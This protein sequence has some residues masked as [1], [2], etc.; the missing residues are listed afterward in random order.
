MIVV[1]CILYIFILTP[2]R[3][4]LYFELKSSSN[5]KMTCIPYFLNPND[6]LEVCP[7]ATTVPKDLFI[8]K[9]VLYDIAVTIKRSVIGLMKNVLVF[10]FV[11]SGISICRYLSIM[12]C[13][14]GTTSKDLQIEHSQKQSQTSSAPKVRQD[15]FSTIKRSIPGVKP[16]R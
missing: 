1:D 14:A 2:S 15:R 13:E 9:D 4:L 5:E 12:I 3:L 7:K 16:P 10:Q 6:G 8:H 11:N